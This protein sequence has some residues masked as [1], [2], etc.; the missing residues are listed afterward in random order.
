MVVPASDTH[1][2]RP[3]D[4]PGC[5]RCGI[6]CIKGGP[7]LHGE[8]R[9]LVKSGL[10]P[11]AALVT[12]RVGELVHQP[13]TDTVV[14]TT[15]EML[16]ISGVKGGWQCRFYRAEEGGCTI[17]EHRPSACRA[18][19][20]WDIAEISALMGTDLLTRFEL[21]E[22]TDSMYAYVEEHEQRFSCPDLIDL[23]SRGI[24]SHRQALEKLI[25]DELGFRVQVTARFSLSLGDELFSLGRPLFSVL[26]GIG[27]ALREINQRLVIIS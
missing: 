18:M 17:Y 21:I 26:S 27:V 8:D 5:R 11:P 15:H 10:L 24:S 25:N 3:A 20:C 6:C 23:Q 13:L 22:K 19:K 4:A 16:K 14:P 1:L 12:I 2:P 9:W 7:V